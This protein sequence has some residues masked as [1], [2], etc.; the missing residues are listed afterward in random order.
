MTSSNGSYSFG[1][2]NLYKGESAASTHRSNLKV[3]IGYVF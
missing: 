2:V 3:G 1:M